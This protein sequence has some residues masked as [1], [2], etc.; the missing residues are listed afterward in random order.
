MRHRVK[1][2]KFNRHSES[3]KALIKSLACALFEHGKIETTL[4]KAK[5]LRPH[6]EKLITKAKEMTLHNRRLLIAA[7]QDNKIVDKLFDEIGPNFKDR[8]GGYTRIQRTRVREGDVTQM[9][10]ISL[11]ETTKLE[12]PKEKPVKK[13]PKAT[14]SKKSETKKVESSK[15]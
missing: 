11:V 3:R 13:A 6:V 15:K 4:P 14:V 2:K 12:E 5:Y 8:N 7:L 10:S 1:T 9:A